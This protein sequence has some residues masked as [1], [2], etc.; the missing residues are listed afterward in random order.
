MEEQ[1][2]SMEETRQ[3]NEALQLKMKELDKVIDQAGR[4]VSQLTNYPAFA[5]AGGARRTTIRRFDLIMVDVNSFIVVVM[6]DNH[7]VKN[8]LI[9]LP[10]ELSEPQLQLLTTLLLKLAAPV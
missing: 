9:H 6:T 7:V 2:L 1:R 10:T 4:M 8:K 3:I 5:L